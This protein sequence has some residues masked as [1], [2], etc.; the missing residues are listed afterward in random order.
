MQLKFL[1][2]AADE[3]LTFVEKLL[4][5]QIASSIPQIEDALLSFLTIFDLRS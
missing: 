4:Q 3:F 1:F 2:L 5:G